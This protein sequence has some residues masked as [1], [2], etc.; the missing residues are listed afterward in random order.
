MHRSQS[1][2]T[3]AK[4]GQ[5]AALACVLLAA[6]VPAAAEAVSL[7]LNAEQ[8]GAL[9]SGLAAEN[10]RLRENGEPKPF[11][12]LPPESPA[13]VAIL[14]E[15]SR[16]SGYYYD[17]LAAAMQGFQR[18]AL[19]GHWYS[20]STF[21]NKLEVRADFTRPAGKIIEAF[22]QLGSPMWNEINTYDAV[23]EMLD[24]M[25]RLPGRKILIVIGS[26]LDTFSGHTLDDVKHKVDSSNVTIF[27]AG[28][29]SALRTYYDAYMGPTSR[30]NLMQAQSFLR[31]LADRS[32]GF[33]WFPRHP[34]GFPDVIRGMMQSIERQYR[35]EY[36]SKA[37]GS[38][39]FQK[40]D[41]EAFRVVDDR[42]QEFD[43]LVRDG[44]R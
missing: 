31:M 42:R 10:F 12:L 7:Y 9:V 32:G 19:D 33:A 17:D 28:A 2:P 40:V 13:S 14:L 25:D 15:F 27:T 16:G 18:H 4:K 37:R 8:G 29:G 35:L 11:Q 41:V 39:T 43:V 22:G 38:G 5:I 3:R 21:S 23:Y 36:D 24:K 44:W 6:A 34:N 30:L 26:G 20:L 1:D